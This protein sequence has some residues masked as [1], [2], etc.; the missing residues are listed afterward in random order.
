L[1]GP[2]AINLQG[3][4]NVHDEDESKEVGDRLYEQFAWPLEQE[5]YGE[6]IAITRGGRTL[7]G[8]TLLDVARQAKDTFGERTFLFKIGP[9]A[10]W[11]MGMSVRLGSQRASFREF[12]GA[13]G[14]DGEDK[15]IE[16]ILVEERERRGY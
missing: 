11:R 15:S 8:P 5:H 2:F 12:V 4:G 16:Q 10:V 3:G 14:S 9:K 7:L 13:G 1:F 6:F